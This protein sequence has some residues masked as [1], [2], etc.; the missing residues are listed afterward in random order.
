MGCEV[1][2]FC[3]PYFLSSLAEL[4][5]NDVGALYSRS[6]ISGALRHYIT[7]AIHTRRNLKFSFCRSSLL[8]VLP[9]GSLRKRRSAAVR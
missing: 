4:N 5:V 1:F 6:N 7:N 3:M 9:L 2:L 8:F